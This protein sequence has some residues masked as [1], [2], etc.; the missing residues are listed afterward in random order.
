[1]PACGELCAGFVIISQ[2][3]MALHTNL[4]PLQWCPHWTLASWT[5]RTTLGKLLCSWNLHS[6]LPMNP[7]FALQWGCHKLSIK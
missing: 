6:P 7:C 4:S 2:E 1:V 5:D 3:D